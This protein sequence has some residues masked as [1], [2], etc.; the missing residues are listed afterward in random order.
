MYISHDNT[1]MY[2]TQHLHITQ[3]A[4]RKTLSVGRSIRVRVLKMHIRSEGNVCSKE[5]YGAIFVKPS[6]LCDPANLL[7][8]NSLVA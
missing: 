5:E 1:N 4:P 7:L 3:I 6:Q 2:I 8:A